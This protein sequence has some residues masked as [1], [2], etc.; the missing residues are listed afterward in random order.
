MRVV[1]LRKVLNRMASIYAGQ[2]EPCSLL[3]KPEGT[4]EQTAVSWA[5]ANIG[6]AI[7]ALQAKDG[8][9]Q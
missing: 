6:Q 1:W 5:V 7:V 4:A 8:F 2:G 9:I 3:P